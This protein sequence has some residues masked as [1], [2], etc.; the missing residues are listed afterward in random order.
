[1]FDETIYGA[2][3]AIALLKNDHDK[4]KGLFDKFE[5]ATTRAQKKKIATEIIN[6]LKLHAA[7][8]E[9]IFYPSVRKPVGKDLM[10]EAD[11]EHHVA[12]VLIAE[13]ERMDGSEEHYDAKVKVLGENIRH[14]IKEE[15]HQMFSKA[16]KAE[17]DFNMIGQEMLE[18]KEELKKS[19][20]PQFA[21][22]KMVAAVKGKGDSPAE[23]AKI[24]RSA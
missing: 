9:E 19:G 21:E 22:E 18:R 2:D 5:D 23:N 20:I 8:E 11:E 1:M 24:K 14:H 16:R 13:I 12:K 17:V 7:V 4:V 6:E 15:E 3:D 10:T